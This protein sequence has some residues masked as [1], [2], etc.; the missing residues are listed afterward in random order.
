MW[1]HITNR[2]SWPNPMFVVFLISKDFSCGYTR[3]LAW[4][5][6]VWFKVFSYMRFRG[7]PH[8][9]NRLNVKELLAR[10]R[11]N[12]WSLSDCNGT[13]TYSHLV[14]NRTLNHL[15]KQASLVK[16]L[17]VRL[18]TKCLWVRVPLQSLI[19]IQL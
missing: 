4:L 17:S 11:C 14:H 10:N 3:T 8:S 12:I 6:E 13:R 9:T 15:A 19:I 5:C 2:L 7:N 16:W 18:K 1:W